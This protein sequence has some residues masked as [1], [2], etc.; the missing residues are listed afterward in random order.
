MRT[1]GADG[2]AGRLA[3]VAAEVV[4]ND[5]LAHGQGW[6]QHLLDIER[7][8]LAVDGTV[9]DPGRADPVVTQ[10]CD[11]GHGLPVAER[12]RCFET[13]PLCPPAAQRCHVGLDPGLV[14]KDEARGV[15]PALMGL[16]ADPFTGDVV[17]ILLGRPNGFF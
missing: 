2:A 10:R 1:P 8:E 16:P 11:E 14:D 6:C 13:L 12:S 15:N 9:D 4:E 3:L 7:E 5:D 17:P